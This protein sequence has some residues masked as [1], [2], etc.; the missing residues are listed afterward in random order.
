MT[1]P[2]DPQQQAVYKWEAEWKAWNH[3]TATLPE[4]RTVVRWALR[5]YGIKRVPP[6]VKQHQSGEYA[7]SIYHPTRRGVISFNAK[8][9]KNPAT[10]LHEVAHQIC[11]TVFPAPETPW[12][13]VEWLGIYMALMEDANVIPT[14]ALHATALAHGLKW[15]PYTE[16]GP[17]AFRQRAKAA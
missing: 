9:S 7:F 15:L 4:L 6:A 13:G 11:D 16:I 17:K 8:T 2:A 1:R 5:R 3:S 14:V 10:A 12:H